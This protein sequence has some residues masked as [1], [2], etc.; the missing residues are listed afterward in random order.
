[1]LDNYCS[2]FGFEWGCQQMGDTFSFF[3][4]GGASQEAGIP[5]ASSWA[6]KF[7][8]LPFD[9]NAK[10]LVSKALE[11]MSG[12]PFDTG[13]ERDGER[14]MRALALMATTNYVNF[15]NQEFLKSLQSTE[16]IIAKQA[17][18]LAL[19]ALQDSMVLDQ[20]SELSYLR[21]LIHFADWRTS[22]ARFFSLNYDNSV[23]IAAQQLGYQCLS[24]PGQTA[25]RTHFG[26]NIDV[27]TIT[28]LKINGSADWICD[29]RETGFGS[30]YQL[31]A[32]SGTMPTVEQACL[33]DLITTPW[34]RQLAEFQLATFEAQIMD[35]A[36]LSV[37]GYSFRRQDI[38]TILKRW[39]TSEVSQAL[40][41]VDTNPTRLHTDFID[42]CED[43]VRISLYQESASRYVKRIY[44]LEDKADDT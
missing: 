32:A 16:V 22:P 13:D 1:M 19:K 26:I 30:S 11:S 15:E 42:S 17:F 23:E 43:Y 34:S 8:N 44:L 29:L 4:G 18:S 2:G 31:R 12:G 27:P 7:D 38:N 37:I 39:A 20:D 9:A 28:L 25:S 40:T 41:I 3:L 6:A 35:S 21:D 33:F 10:I 14:F 24:F 36:F 5:L